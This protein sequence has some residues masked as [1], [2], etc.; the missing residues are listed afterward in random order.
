MVGCSGR[1]PTWHAPIRDERLQDKPALVA[2]KAAAAHVTAH[3]MVSASCAPAHAPTKPNVA[4]R[5]SAI[6]VTHF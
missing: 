6:E 3:Y 5:A 1:G 4:L 2:S